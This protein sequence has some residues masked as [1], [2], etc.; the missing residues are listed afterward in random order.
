MKSSD[1]TPIPPVTVAPRMAWWREPLL[2]FVLLGAA[3][4]GL[5]HWLL[6]RTDDPHRIVVGPEVDAHSRQVFA[7]SRG[8]D[9]DAAELAALRQRWIDNEVLYREG[10]SMRV[11]R[12]DDAIRERV[13]FKALSLVDAGVVRPPMDD[14][15]LRAWFEK[16]RA[17]YDEGAR[18]DFDEAVLAGG[19]QTDDAVRAFVDALNAGTP[20]DL[21]AGLRV[22]TA[23]PA[24]SLAPAYGEEFEPALVAGPAAADAPWRAL[25]T[26]D[27]LRA[28]RLRA[29]TPARPADYDRIRNLVAQDWTDATMA[30]QRTAAVRALAGKYRIEVTAGAADLVSTGTAAGT[31]AASATTEPA[32]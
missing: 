22:F 8:R 9:P 7:A 31:A 14:A 12:G 6:S 3:V 1:P 4:F 5:D 23:R 20:G 15:T 28:V 27:G 2:H 21:Q 11:D 25:P 17:K 29:V 26:R 16:N 32:K 19:R 18:Y 30:E 24:G 13:I 10:L